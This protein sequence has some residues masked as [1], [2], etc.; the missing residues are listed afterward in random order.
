[1]KLEKPMEKKAEHPLF[2]PLLYYNFK[3]KMV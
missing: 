2:D 3:L 1:M